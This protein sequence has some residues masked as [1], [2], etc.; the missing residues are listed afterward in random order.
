MVGVVVQALRGQHAP[1]FKNSISS[2]SSCST[3]FQLNWKQILESVMRRHHLPDRETGNVVPLA[4]LL[5]TF[6]AS[7]LLRV[8]QQKSYDC[9]AIGEIE[10][11][12]VKLPSVA[13]ASNQNEKPLEQHKI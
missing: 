7:I 11:F 5:F 13:A 1:Y 4:L 8:I 9:Q 10:I 6:D 2:S 12:S 3:L